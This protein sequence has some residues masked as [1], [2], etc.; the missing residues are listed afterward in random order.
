M[1]DSWR[2]MVLKGGLFLALLVLLAQSAFSQTKKPPLGGFGNKGTGG[3]S[4][5]LWR[6]TMM[7]ETR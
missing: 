7:S 4:G 2:S 3:F 5:E 6:A 1:F